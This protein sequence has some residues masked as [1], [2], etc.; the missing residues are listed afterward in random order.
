MFGIFEI[1]FLCSHCP[2]YDDDRKTLRCLG[3]HGSPKLWRYHPEPMNRFEKF[4]MRFAVIGMIFFIL[5]IAA[6]GYGIGYLVVNYETFGLLPL[7]G[8]SGIAFAM[9]LA[10][11]SFVAV[12]KTHFC[13]S[14]V[15]FSCPLNTVP[16]DL[17]DGY[18]A[19]NR[20]MREAWEKA[21]YKLDA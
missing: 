10:S 15:N 17:V 6:F 5:P 2:Y 11:V 16:K 20:V 8:L 14:C 19:K 9:L 13:T 3:N 1:R 12:V 18:L 7:V 21:G 4:L